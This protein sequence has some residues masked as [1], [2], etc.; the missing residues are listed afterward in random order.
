MGSRYTVSLTK[1]VM[2]LLD[3]ARG[4]H[5]NRS[6]GK[7][8]GPGVM[9]G[10]CG[11][12]E[13][14]RGE[15]GGE[16]PGTFCIRREAGTGR[17]REVGKLVFHAFLL[18]FCSPSFSFLNPALLGLLRNPHLAPGPGH[19]PWSKPVHASLAV[20]ALLLCNLFTDWWCWTGSTT[21]WKTWRAN[22]FLDNFYA[23]PRDLHR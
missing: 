1:T 21:V 2:L 4:F 18:L 5:S 17:N 12:E 14:S 11:E 10:S 19:S 13:D 3:E 6:D 7:P 23:G 15:G 8:W 9:W 16:T 20:S 22:I